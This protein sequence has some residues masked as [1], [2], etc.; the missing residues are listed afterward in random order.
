V[1][2][3]VDAAIERLARRQ[4]GVFSRLQAL[5]RGATTSLVERRCRSGRW[6]RV[7]RGVYALAGTDRTLRQRVM[8]AVLQAGPGC[9]AS[10]LCAALLRALDGVNTAP[11]EIT[12]PRDVRVRPAGTR[13]HVS[14]DAA[15][16]EYHDVDGIPVAAPTEI[17]VDLAFTATVPFEVVERVFECAQRR[18]ETSHEAVQKR[19]ATV[20]RSGKRGARRARR[21]IDA[22]V[23]DGAVNH[24]EL[25]TR[26]FQLLR[27]AGLPLPARQQVIL[28]PDGRFAYA[29]YGYPGTSGVVELIGFRW[30]S[31]SAAL[32]SD[33]ERSNDVQLEDKRTV[34]F[35]WDHVTRRREYVV[36]TMTR[37]LAH[38]GVEYRCENAQE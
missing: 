26:F 20:A 32:T 15:T 29:D 2:N 38:I 4:H 36:R 27:S 16:A 14:A 22:L 8:I 37:F 7:A 30:H 28:R 18:G 12:V 13:V 11:V 23:D 25:E 6:I 21:I 9:Y 17:V 3:H 31:S 5:E 19:L 24:S 10:H 35:T 34:Q 33:V 1:A